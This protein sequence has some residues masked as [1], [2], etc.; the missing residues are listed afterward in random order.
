MAQP[1]AQP[2]APTTCTSGVSCFKIEPFSSTGG[3]YFLKVTITTPGSVE[4]T[5]LRLSLETDAIVDGSAANAYNYLSTDSLFPLQAGTGTFKSGSG[6]WMG[7]SATLN[8]APPAGYTGFRLVLS[9]G[10]GNP[11]GSSFYILLTAAP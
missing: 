4:F 9:T 1:E 2:M 7:Y 11:S 10:T 6:G 5:T 8:M 3:S